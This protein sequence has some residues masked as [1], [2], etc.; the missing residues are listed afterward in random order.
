MKYRINNLEELQSW[1]T[2]FIQKLTNDSSAKILCL[3]GEVGAGKTTFAQYVARKLGITESI[4]SP[5]FVIQKQY[6]VVNHPWIKKMIHID[7]YRLEGKSD[8]E[9]LGWNELITN[10]D[11]LI[12]LEWPEMIAGA[13]LPNAIHLHFEIN[14]DHTRTITRKNN[15]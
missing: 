7:A 6:P 4:T 2:S 10:T 3:S 14:P 5:T 1:T 9:Y 15:E 12:L 13:S 11:H 8:I